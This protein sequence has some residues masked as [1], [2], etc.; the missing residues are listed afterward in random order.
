MERAIRQSQ[1]GRETFNFNNA[2]MRN[3]PKRIDIL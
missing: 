3:M 1:L 2:G